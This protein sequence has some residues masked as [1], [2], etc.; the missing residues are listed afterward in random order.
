VTHQFFK[1]H[2]LRLINS[3]LQINNWACL[4]T[5]IKDKKMGDNAQYL[6]SSRDFNAFDIH[7]KTDYIT[8]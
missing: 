1:Q 6:D 5:T 8:K 2:G 3:S 7:V 4:L